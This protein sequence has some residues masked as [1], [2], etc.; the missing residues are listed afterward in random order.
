MVR[1]KEEAVMSTAQKKLE[2]LSG[3]T[4]REAWLQL[5]RMRH[6]P[7]FAALLAHLETIKGTVR[8]SDVERA[9]Q[10]FL[11]TPKD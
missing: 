6:H 7:N 4:S 1:Y 5:Q 9:A 10:R 8:N 3:R 11:D 2:R